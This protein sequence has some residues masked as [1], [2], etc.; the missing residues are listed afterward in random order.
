[1]K[2]LTLLMFMLSFTLLI[3]SCNNIAPSNEYSV[4]T[5][6]RIE[7]IETEQFTD[8]D[9]GATGGAN[10]CP[11]HSIE[12]HTYT[13]EMIDYVGQEQFRI[14]DEANMDKESGIEG[15]TYYSNIYRFINDFEIPKSDFEALCFGTSAYYY[16]DYNVELLYGSDFSAI[17][18]YYTSY[19]E[20]EDYREKL[21]SLGD[22]KYGILEYAMS[23]KDEKMKSFFDSHCDNNI[24]DLVNWSVADFVR[25]TGINRA[26]IEALISDITIIEHPGGVFTLNCFDFDFDYLYSEDNAVS[27]SKDSKAYTIQKI[28][29]DLRLCKQSPINMSTNDDVSVNK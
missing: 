5:D 22:I 19:S 8:T 29:E 11:I 26:D 23:S 9:S 28:N 6:E 12:F 3:M 25:E 10:L 18:Q 2:R 20:R 17:N 24:L 21:A 13:G 1:M 27:T 15:C 16:F 7:P 14:W 4:Q